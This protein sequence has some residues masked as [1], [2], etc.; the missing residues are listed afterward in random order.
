MGRRLQ[1]YRH[2]VPPRQP[3]GPCGCSHLLRRTGHLPR[4]HRAGLDPR[5]DRPVGHAAA[6]RKPRQGRTGARQGNLY[7]RDSK[8]EQEP[9]RRGDHLHRRIGGGA[10]VGIRVCGRLH[11]RLQCDLR[12]GR[13]SPDLEDASPAGER[14]GGHGGSSCDQCGRRGPDGRACQAGRQPGRGRIERGAGVG[15]R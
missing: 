15:H 13:G 3:H 4:D 6:D 11:A 1:A 7:Q 8:S 10:V 9:G 12:C 14:H 2:R 5:A